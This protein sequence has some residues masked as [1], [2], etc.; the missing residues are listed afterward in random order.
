MDNIIDYKRIANVILHVAPDVVALQ[1]LDSATLRSKG[2]IILNE[3]ASLMDMNKIYGLSITY[4]G[5]KYRIGILTKEKPV[6]WDIVSLPGREERRSLLIVELKNY[7]ICC[8][9][10][11][12][13]EEDRIA[14]V[15]IINNA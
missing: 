14:S 10:F 5:G 12:L 11:S 3:L 6:K 2:I 8:T 4:Q 13:I 7:V 1:E 15:N 9:H